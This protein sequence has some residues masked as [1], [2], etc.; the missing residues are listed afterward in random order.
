MK[1]MT[2]FG[3]VFFLFAGIVSACGDSM[4]DMDG[5]MKGGGCPMM[6]GGGMQG[7][8]PMGGSMEMHSQTG[9][10]G[11]MGPLL[12]IGLVILVFLLVFK[13]SRELLALSRKKSPR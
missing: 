13:L 8:M 7:M 1:K 10:F 4:G 12:M 6:K 11:L 2:A 9:F 5:M 3:M